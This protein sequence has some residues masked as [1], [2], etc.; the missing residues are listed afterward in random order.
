MKPEYIFFVTLELTRY[1]TPKQIQSIEK[2]IHADVYL[3][4]TI[5]MER[6]PLQMV[7]I[8]HGFVTHVA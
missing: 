4:Q 3:K 6:M 2:E 1:S 5:I 7:S 8:K